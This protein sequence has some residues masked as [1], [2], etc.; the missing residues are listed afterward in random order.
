MTTR[1]KA[2]ELSLKYL[3]I[4]EKCLNITWND[5][6]CPVCILEWIS[7]EAID[8]LRKQLATLLSGTLSEKARQDSINY[9][10]NHIQTV[11][12]GLAS[13]F[14]SFV[15]LGF[16][17]GERVVL[18]DVISSRLLVEKSITPRLKSIL[19]QT[20]CNLLLLRPVVEQGGLVI[21][22][23]PTCWSDLARKID[24]ELR[25]QGNKS[26]ATL[27]ISM[28]MVA[29]EEGLVLHP[30]TQLVD[31]LKPKANERVAAH[32]SDLYSTENYIFHSA[33][34]SFLRDQRVA[35]LEGVH[36]ADFYRIVSKHTEL[37]RS[38][39]KHFLP[40]MRGL[41]TVQ[42][43]LEIKNLI[44]ELVALIG[45]RNADLVEYV[46]DGSEATATFMLTSLASLSA[47]LNSL[48]MLAASSIALPLITMIRKWLK[49]PKNDVMVQAFMELH[50]QERK[51]DYPAIIVHRS[52]MEI[53]ESIT[54]M[55]QKYMSF[56]WTEERHDFLKTLS[57]KVAKELLNTLE[58]EEIEVIVNWRKFQSDYIGDYLSYLWQLD[59]KSFWKHIEITFKSEEGMLIYD[60]D[61]HIQIMCSNDMP[62]SVWNQLL[63]S[64]FTTYNAE[65]LGN[66][67]GYILCTIAD[68][69]RFQT[70][71][72]TGCVK[73]RRTLVKWIKSITGKERESLLLYL[74]HVYN[75]KFPKWLVGSMQILV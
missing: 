22:P 44:S 35:Y 73:Q 4:V 30:F 41:S 8:K 7:N 36:C 5:E 69:I 56:Y 24:K 71:D 12:F 18:W 50:E 49:P 11:G 28:A 58:P 67:Y 23:H 46:A 9:S 15:K 64:L 62:L 55:H 54:K 16:I 34:S 27:G 31:K 53:E 37:Y 3:R 17:Y 61:D 19:A 47:G 75:N 52:R 10:K 68:I 13:D 48:N 25:S 14:D 70:E 57:P 42:V 45:K 74:N 32:E 26:S 39:R 43:Q 51:Q 65:L 40:N 2:T 38:L 63:L 1:D 66:N 33:I 20:A 60:S 72:A 29:I 59:E 21:L 6:E